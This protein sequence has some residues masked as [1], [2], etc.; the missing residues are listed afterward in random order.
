MRDSV[1]VSSFPKASQGK[2]DGDG[3]GDTETCEEVNTIES[4]GGY[5]TIAGEQEGRDDQI[6]DWF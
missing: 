6:S 1:Y 5:W 2:T 4:S 3:G